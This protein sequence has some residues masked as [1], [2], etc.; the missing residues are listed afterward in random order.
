MGQIRKIAIVAIL[1][2]CGASF[3]AQNDGVE[4]RFSEGTATGAAKIVQKYELIPKG[5]VL[6]GAA[7]GFAEVKEVTYDKDANEFTLNGDAKYK[8]PIARRDFV[9]LFKT[10]QK[11]DRLGVTLIQGET[12]CYGAISTAEKMVEP[13]VETDKLLGGIIYGL[14]HLLTVKLPGEYKPKKATDRKIPVVAFTVFQG[15]RFNQKKNSKEY[16]RSNVNM[17]ITLIPLSEEKTKTGGHLPDLKLTEGYAMEQTDA[18][19]LD[20]LRKHHDQY[21]EIECIKQAAA[22]GEAAAFARLIRDS[23]I[24]AKD[25]LALLD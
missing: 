21:L 14:D 1:A 25:F 18:D 3:G 12:R 5:V 10:L 17:D 15:Y 20:H 24:P 22:V 11:D 6:E 7:E 2:V 16:V 4:V 19:N 9:R 23:K 8:L 13:L